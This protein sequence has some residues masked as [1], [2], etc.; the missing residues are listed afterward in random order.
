MA[1]PKGVRSSSSMQHCM[2]FARVSTRANNN[3]FRGKLRGVTR[4]AI[5]F[6]LFTIGVN[7][8]L[9]RK[10]TRKDG[11]R[12]PLLA[13]ERRGNARDPAPK[14]RRTQ[15]K[16]SLLA[17]GTFI[18][19]GVNTLQIAVINQQNLYVRFHVHYSRQQK[20]RTFTFHATEISS[21]P[22]LCIRFRG[23]LIQP[24]AVC[25]CGKPCRPFFDRFP[26]ANSVR[27]SHVPF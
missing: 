4:R 22:C 6:C 16:I 11:R 18:T 12:F 23:V 24:S 20:G 13:G 26:A 14:A 27:T 10:R 2:T 17:F 5:D 7:M 19:A 3:Q 15:K 1:A 25:D 21:A 8:R 9:R